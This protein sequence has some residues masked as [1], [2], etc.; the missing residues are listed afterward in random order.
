MF[1]NSLQ[2]NSNK[3]YENKK[4]L[5]FC[6]IVNIAG[7]RKIGTKVGEF[8]TVVGH[9]YVSL[10]KKGQPPEKIPVE[11]VHSISDKYNTLLPS[12]EVYKKDDYVCSLA[13]LQYSKKFSHIY[14]E[15]LQNF[16]QNSNVKINGFTKILGRSIEQIAL[17]KTGGRLRCLASGKWKS[18]VAV[19]SR[20][21]L[22][23][24]IPEKYFLMPVRKGI[25][26]LF[27]L[28]E[29]KELNSVSMHVPRKTI[30]KAREELT[31]NPMIDTKY[32]F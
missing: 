22:E 1:K 27:G 13:Y 7:L 18:P 11:I 8:G 32:V 3:N 2:I 19:Y 20:M 24:D 17:L 12:L 31:K 14:V 30:K 5:A 26:K 28:F 6:G 9:E 16:A 29:K 10:H 21:G 25:M 15:W 23:P 4:N